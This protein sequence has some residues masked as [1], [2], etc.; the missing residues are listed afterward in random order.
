[1]AL[2][3]RDFV[4]PPLDGSITLPETI[5]FHWRHNADLPAYAF[6]R[7]GQENQKPTEISYLE[8]GRA[9]HRVAHYVDSKFQSNG[10][11]PVVALIALSDTLLYQAVCVGIMKAGFIPFPIS[12]RNTA[13]AVINL[14]KKTDCHY[15]LSTC[16]TLKELLDNISVE[17]G[18][19]ESP[20]KVD[21]EEIPR[22]YDIF[23]KLGEEREDDPFTPYRS[24]K[25]YAGLNDVGIYLHSSGSTGFPKAI[26]QTHQIM[27]H[28]ALFSCGRVFSY[29]QPRLR[30]AVMH[31]PPFHTMGVYT[32]VF[33]PLYNCATSAI[34]PPVTDSP[35]KLPIMPTPDNILDHLR[36]TKSNS[37][38]AVPTLLQVWG[39]D[40]DSIELLSSLEIVDY[41]GGAIAPKI[42]DD[43]T[44]AG[45]KLVPTYGGT[46]F[47]APTEFFKRSEDAADWMYLEFDERCKVRWIP[48][49]D[50]T[51]ECQFL[52]TET[53]S[54]P[55]ENLPDVRGYATNDLFEPHPTKKHL[56]RIVGRLDDVIIHASGEKTVPAPIEDVVMSSPYIMGTVMF[57]RAHNQPG[58]LIEPKPNYAIDVEDSNQLA[59]F[60][61]LI[62]PVIEEANKVA[63]TFSKIFKEMILITNKNKP[64]PRAGKGTVMRK[65]A[66]ISHEQEIEALYATVES[67]E[68]TESIKPP[69]VW[70]K[71]ALTHWL[72]EQAQDLNGGKIV[73]PADD[74]FEHGFDSLSATILR[75]RIFG[76]LQNLKSSTATSALQTINQNIVYNYPNVN[77]LSDYLLNLISSDAV[78]DSPKSRTEAIE[79]MIAKYAFT[80]KEI[81]DAAPQASPKTSEIVVLLTGSTGNL[82]SQVLEQLLRHPDVSKV[83]ALNRPS[84]GAASIS[85]RH[86]DRF[87]DK[88]LDTALLSSSKL[89]SLESDVSREYLGLPEARYKDIL[90]SVDVI[91]HTAWR[92]DFNLSL[93]SFESNIRGTHNLIDVARSKSGVKFIFTSS[94]ASALSWDQSLGPYPEE[95]L[96]DAKYAVGQ[97]YGESKYVTERILATSG[98]NFTSLRIGQISGGGPRGAWATTDWLPILI[99]S[100]L[101]LGRLPAANGVVSWIQMD[102]VSASVLDLVFFDEAYPRAINVLHPKPVHWND[103]MSHIADALAKE[104]QTSP[105]PFVPFSEWISLLED[106]AKS[107]SQE[108]DYSQ[109]PA[110]KLHDFF[111]SMAKEDARISTSG[112]TDAEV[113]GMTKF[114]LEN[115]HLVSETLTNVTPLTA[116]EAQ[117]WVGYWNEVGLFDL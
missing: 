54:L 117:K 46:E 77:A 50:G 33:F 103:I 79:E 23:P 41:S 2:Y 29:H 82:G 107:G 95:V 112:Q 43:L 101:A 100:S 80:Q 6:S 27:I 15:L 24:P 55:V 108:K 40:Q 72:V 69:N 1:M 113:G 18:E 110:I 3:A 36:R 4:Y 39:Q 83:Y 85:E 25:D 87:R 68:N 56:W 57:G 88:G 34:Y 28:W 93:A 66:V 76:A 42:A 102:A 114:S 84:F 64:L 45:V 91:V 59:Q 63:P 86:L 105:S 9:C 12:P 26:P 37:V 16:V 65:L 71:G 14:L 96:M 52:T 99:K 48:Q 106:R 109:V 111:N 20:Y 92:L 8:F 67:T 51:Y 5:E 81:V 73:G 116:S 115:M 94:I 61:N 62:W 32:Q 75:R 60:R 44:A 98:V 49:G 19:E 70:D 47:G 53:H 31:L 17:L 13:A 7:D 21:V 10:G 22:L 74:L 35:E 78:A 90:E 104:K 11:R 58:I 30:A 38:V 89:V 97:G